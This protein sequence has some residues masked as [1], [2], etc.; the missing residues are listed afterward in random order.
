M[1]FVSDDA[2]ADGAPAMPDTVPMWWRGPRGWFHLLVGVAVLAWLWSWSVPGTHFLV[3]MASSLALLAAG[4]L[5]SIHAVAFVVARR[6]GRPTA[7]TPRFLLAPVVGAIAV[8]LVAADVP[9]DARWSLSRSAFEDVVDDA[10]KDPDYRST[11]ER[12]IGLYT[13]GHVYSQGEIVIFWVP[14]GGFV[15]PVG[16]AYLPEGPL[17]EIGDVGLNHP[18]FRHIDG[19]WY[20]YASRF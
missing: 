3:F 19:P 12:R 14:A 16:F 6:R 1:V 10:L 13:V 20:T 8:A 15:D 9:F 4:V 7:G 5:W 18:Q 2:R 11:A 17:P